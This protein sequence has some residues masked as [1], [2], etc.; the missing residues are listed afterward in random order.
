MACP[1]PPLF[2]PSLSIKTRL[3]GSQGPWRAIVGV[4]RNLFS[5]PP[6]GKVSSIPGFSRG[7]IKNAAPRNPRVSTAKD[8]RR[9][10][11]SL[12]QILSKANDGTWSSV[13]ISTDQSQAFTAW[14]S[15]RETASGS[16]VRELRFYREAPHFAVWHAGPVDVTTT[17]APPT[18]PEPPSVQR[19]RPRSLLERR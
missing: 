12:F 11:V 15:L 3:M 9:E 2:L 16:G 18:E 17:N 19:N 1:T 7:M 6:G 10:S 8:V 4:N 5:R 13:F 14:D